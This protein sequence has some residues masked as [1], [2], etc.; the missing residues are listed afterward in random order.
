MTDAHPDS[1]SGRGDAAPAAS[2]PGTELAVLSRAEVDLLLAPYTVSLQEWLK[3]LLTDA[4][5]PEV[6]QDEIGIGLLA[7]ILTAETSEEALRALDLQRAKVLAGGEPGGHSPLLE[8]TGARAL[9][10]TF[11]DGPS[12]Y[13]IVQATILATGERIQFTTGA[14]AVQAVIVKHIGEGWLPFRALLS[15]RRQA[16]QRGFYPLNLEAGG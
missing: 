6:E 1:P 14:R 2:Q 5:F 9:R 11:E 15:I 8:I 7:S 4:E 16:T 12:C 3:M 10:S 13:A